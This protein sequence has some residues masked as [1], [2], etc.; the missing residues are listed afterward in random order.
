[1]KF[2]IFLFI[3]AHLTNLISAVNSLSNLKT[4]WIQALQKTAIP[5]TAKNNWFKFQFLIFP[6]KTERMW[7]I[8][9]TFK[10]RRQTE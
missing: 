1:M 4:Y 9:S 8:I 10:E 6:K 2:C 3:S 5:Y 7:P